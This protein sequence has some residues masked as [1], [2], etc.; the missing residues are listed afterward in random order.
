MGDLS[1]MSPLVESVDGLFDDPAYPSLKEY[2]I[3]TTGLAYYAD[4]DADFVRRLCRRWRPL[5]VRNCSAYLELL[6]DPVQGASE[7]DALVTEI[8][9]GESH[10][11]RHQEHFD[12]LRNLVLPTLIARNTQGRRIR[13]WCAGSADGAEPYS[14]SVLIKRDMGHLF[15]GWDVTILATD[16]NRQALS[17]AQ[18][19]RF[20]GW[21]FRSTPE[22]LRRVCFLKEGKYWKI[23]RRYRD[24][25]SFQYHNL[26]QSS[27]PPLLGCFSEFDLI[28]CRN[29]MIYFGP[30]L[31]GRIV[32]QFHECLAEGGWLLVGPSEP[33]MTHFTLFRPVNAPGVTLYQKCLQA[34]PAPSYQ[35]PPAPALAAL[36]LQ[37][38]PDVSSP[39]P[40]PAQNAPEVLATIRQLADQGEWDGAAQLCRELLQQD[41]FNSLVHFHYALVLEQTGEKDEAERSLRRTIYLDR[42]SVLAHYH[43]G[44]LLR[45]RG[46]WRQALRCFDNT[47]ELLLS[48]PDVE[49]LAGT[50][51]VTVAEFRKLA[52][53]QRAVLSAHLR[54]TE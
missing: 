9:I 11:F 40:S 17:A 30:Q 38:E 13:I 3:A 22:D 1:A 51:G 10:F 52:D 54:G 12:A 41:S 29:V 8:T 15:E 18:E 45:S 26:V 4:K 47:F 34:A 14:L 39:D 25:V 49:I 19:G 5:G 16:I 20:E 33:N 2:V 50:D 35:A 46:D 21:S 53:A 43:L 23:H 24:G 48:R 36:P 42:Q 7:M 28:V 44:V 37:S 27:F 32:R 6:R 31:M